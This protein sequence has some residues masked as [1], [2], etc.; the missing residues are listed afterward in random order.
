[1]VA[2]DLVV[3]LG[4][5]ELAVVFGERRSS[6]WCSGRRGG[7]ARYCSWD[8][9]FRSGRRSS[10]AQEFQDGEACLGAL[11]GDD[12]TRGVPRGSVCSPF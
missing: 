1:M 11:S 6:W 9:G 5:A 12:E 2:A 4:T 7:V 3:V 10:G 8:S